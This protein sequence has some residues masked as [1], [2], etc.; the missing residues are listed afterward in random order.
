MTAQLPPSQLLRLFQTPADQLTARDAA[1]LIENLGPAAPWLLRDEVLPLLA[2]EHPRF[3]SLPSPYRPSLPAGA[4]CCGI[5]YAVPDQYRLLRPAF[6]L[7]VQWRQGS[8]HDPGLPLRLR[9]LANRVQRHFNLN[10]A[11][12]LHRYKPFERLRLAFFDDLLQHESGWAPLAG[13]LYLTAHGG[14]PRPKVWATGCWDG[15]GGIVEVGGLTAKL[16]LARAWGAKTVFVPEKQAA[17]RVE[18]LELGKLCSGLRAPADALRDYRVALDASPLPNDPK[19][20]RLSFYF[21]QPERHPFTTEF[22]RTHFLPE[23]IAERRQQ[24]ATDWPGW[25]PTHLVTVVSG[26][27]ELIPLVAR[28]LGVQSC[29]LLYTRAGD[30]NEEKNKMRQEALLVARQLEASPG[31]EKASCVPFSNDESMATEMG[32]QIAAFA[33]GVLDDRLVFDTTPGTKLMTLALE[34]LARRF[35]P[36]SCLV[37]VRHEMKQQRVN[38][39]TEHLHRWEA[40]GVSGPFV[41]L[42]GENNGV[43]V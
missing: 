31:I 22:Y 41:A 39:F 27:P 25:A 38:P 29:L 24:V 14:K 2:E 36:H 7:P 32:Q 6:L 23:I 21:R 3:A 1:D 8:S 33:D 15:D 26:S 42:P 9:E 20:E 18:D 43:G 5:L 34:Q 13:G 40:G 37:Y 4:G 10:G 35:H 12:S 28:A 16:A 11:W 19:E 30:G 17:D